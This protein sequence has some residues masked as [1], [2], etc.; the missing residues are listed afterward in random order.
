MNTNITKK[1]QIQ[2]K[3]SGLGIVDKTI[4]FALTQNNQEGKHMLYCRRCF[5]S[6][7]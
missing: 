4:S 6:K 2:T 3:H 7:R 5:E 1:E